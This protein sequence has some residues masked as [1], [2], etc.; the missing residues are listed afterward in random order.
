M[1]YVKRKTGRYASLA[2][3]EGV[4]ESEV[5]WACPQ[6][7]GERLGTLV[8]GTRDR[9]LMRMIQGVLLGFMI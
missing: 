6:C 9:G 7:G 2:R 3:W 8:Y 1:G 4:P 5:D